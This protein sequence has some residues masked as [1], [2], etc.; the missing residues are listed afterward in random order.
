ML[1]RRMTPAAGGN[2]HLLFGADADLCVIVKTGDEIDIEA[3]VGRRA[4]P[5]DDGPKLFGQREAHAH[6]PD[7]AAG[8]DPEGEVAVL[9]A[10]AMPA[11][12]KGWRQPKRSLMRVETLPLLSAIPRMCVIAI[13]CL[14]LGLLTTGHQSDAELADPSQAKRRSDTAFAELIPLGS[15]GQ[16]HAGT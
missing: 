12:A 4:D 11:P 5:M 10:K 2:W 7:P 16:R 13:G 1:G 8:A 3:G 6:R 14:R 9:S 15:W